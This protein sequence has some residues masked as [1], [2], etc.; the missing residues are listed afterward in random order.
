MLTFLLWKKEGGK[1]KLWAEWG[2][3]GICMGECGL[4]AGSAT[5]CLNLIVGLV[6]QA[7]IKSSPSPWMSDKAVAN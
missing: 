2:P 7:G 6:G 3:T 1:K 5:E 4:V